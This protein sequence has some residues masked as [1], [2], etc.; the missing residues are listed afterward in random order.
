[1]PIEILFENSSDECKADAIGLIG[2]EIMILIIRVKS[3]CLSVSSV[4]E[5]CE[6][7]VGPKDHT[8]GEVCQS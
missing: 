5:A 1:M 6:E 8:K 7:G 2:R 3:Y 4:V